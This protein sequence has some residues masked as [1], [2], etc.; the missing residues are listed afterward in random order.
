[1]TATVHT[2]R[3]VTANDRLGITL[4]FAVTFHAIVILGVSFDLTD[5][6]TN[7]DSL[8]TLEVTIVNTL[9]NETPEEADYLAQS[10]QKG[11]GNTTERV[12]P[13][14]P[15]ESAPEVMPTPGNAESTVQPTV[16]NQRTRPMEKDVM[17]VVQAEKVI[18][19]GEETPED[20]A[21]APTAA[22]LMRRAE[23]IAQLEAELAESMKVYSKDARV[24]KLLVPNSK[25]HVEAAYVDAW[26]KKVESV[27]DRNY[28]EKA[29]KLK[30]S[31][32]VLMETVINRD[33]EVADIKLIKS[34][35]HKILDDAAKRIVHLASPFGKLPDEILKQTDVVR[36]RRF[37]KFETGNKFSTS[38]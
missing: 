10:D 4:F 28:P 23:E 2:T 26:Q 11:S 27:G 35:G 19:T 31:G 17:T 37:W 30:I 8:P 20:N 9:S 29:K 16:A 6:S 15:P 25:S 12:R 33:G 14:A 34:S 24:P 7:E 22:Q 1:M 18:K 21:E 32:T 13:E 5:P 36:I 38:Q 3:P